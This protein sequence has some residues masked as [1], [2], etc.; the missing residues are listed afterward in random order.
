MSKERPLLTVGLDSQTFR[1]YYY[2]KEEL[3]AF[4]RE[5]G[6]M[7]SGG[8]PE[9]TERIACFLEGRECIASPRI[10]RGRPVTGE[11]TLESLIGEHFVC[12]E[13]HR[14]FFRRVIGG[15]F[16]FTVIFQNWLK[17]HPDSTYAEAV[18][19]WHEL[20][21]EKKQ[22]EIGRQFEYNTYIRDFFGD[23][24]GRKLE[25]AIC[26]WN[27]KKRKAGSHRYEPGDLEALPVNRL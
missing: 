24:P 5:M 7:V 22:P 16:S 6:L 26:C 19:A 3:M 21:K 17:V 13:K 9:L 1:E 20:R 10:F 23:N 14:A 2:L 18:V 15:H 11:I 27:Y 12:S 4:C 25:E 8:K